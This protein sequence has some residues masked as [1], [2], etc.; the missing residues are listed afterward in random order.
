MELQTLTKSKPE[1]EPFVQY[2]NDVT[3]DDNEFTHSEMLI[4]QQNTMKV[5]T[6]YDLICR[7]SKDCEEF[8]LELES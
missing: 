6:Q 5:E 3:L 1:N 7:G 4:K 8:L 2:D